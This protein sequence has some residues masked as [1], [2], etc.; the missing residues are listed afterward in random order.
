[1]IEIIAYSLYSIYLGIKRL[2]VRAWHI[3]FSVFHS[4]DPKYNLYKIEE[5]EDGTFDV[6][7]KHPRG[8]YL[9]ERN[10]PTKEKAEAYIRYQVSNESLIKRYEDRD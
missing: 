4:L 7:K 2:T 9:Y 10:L 6:Y 3:L 1:M 5:D 8:H